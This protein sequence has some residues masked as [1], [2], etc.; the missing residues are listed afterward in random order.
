MSTS[1]II[2]QKK[3]RAK[4]STSH[5]KLVQKLTAKNHKL[6]HTNQA[7]TSGKKYPLNNCERKESKTSRKKR[8]QTRPHQLSK[9]N[10]RPKRKTPA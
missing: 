9:K 4:I 3:F 8:P 1:K 7:K 6:N 2:L 10:E 5:T